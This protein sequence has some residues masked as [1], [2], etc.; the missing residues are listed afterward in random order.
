MEPGSMTPFAAWENFYVI[1]GSSA[2]ALTGLQF[3]VI[4]LGVEI[5]RPG[6]GHATS[7][8]G[9]PTVVHFSAVL[10]NSA[11][12]SAPWRTVSAAGLAIAGFALFGVAYAPIVL[13][14]TLRQKAYV[15][16]LEDWIW[17]IVLPFVAY[18]GLLTSGI[19]LRGDP[20]QWLFV[21]AA[22]A[23][24]LLFIG[25]HNAWDAVTYMALQRPKQPGNESRPGTRRH[26]VDH[27][28]QLAEFQ[29]SPGEGQHSARWDMHARVAREA[30]AARGSASSSQPSSEHTS[31]LALLRQILAMTDHDQPLPRFAHANYGEA[32][33]R[34]HQTGMDARP[35][36]FGFAD[37]Q[38]RLPGQ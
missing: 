29:H 34:A 32:V 38:F 15:P 6:S 17:H 21:I 26:R 14:R 2:A 27:P 3:V 7:A 8:F 11:I 24:L 25:I 22:M 1:D 20:A 18:A 16:V 9:T 4:V 36:L 30:R 10:L 28:W 13:R 35:R 12:L 31:P 37:S 23:L 19:F 5:N 33:G